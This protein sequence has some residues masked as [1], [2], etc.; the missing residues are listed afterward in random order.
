MIDLKCNQ[1]SMALSQENNET[2]IVINFN[3][4]NENYYI[5]KF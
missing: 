4:M 1:N 2:E 5:F 3:V